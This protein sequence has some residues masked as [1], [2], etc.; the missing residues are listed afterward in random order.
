M[1][2]NGNPLIWLYDGEKYSSYWK[3]EKYFKNWPS[4]MIGQFPMKGTSHLYLDSSSSGELNLLRTTLVYMIPLRDSVDTNE[5]RYT[6][7]EDNFIGGVSERLKLF[8]RIMLP[9]KYKMNEQAVYLFADSGDIS[10]IFLS[11]AK[12]RFLS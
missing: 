8:D 7:H 5:W 10:K 9:G 12:Y 4:E 3:L 11:Y 2:W 6:E 1:F